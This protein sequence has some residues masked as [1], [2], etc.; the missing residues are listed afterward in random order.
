MPGF[1]VIGHEEQQAINEVFANGGILYRYGFVAQRKGIYKVTEFEKAFAKK[2][3]VNHAQAVNSGTTALVTALHAL[4]IKQG[5]EVITQCHTFVATVEAIL[6]LG[7]TPV[8]T[9]I[10][11]TLNMDPDD[12]A[13]KITKR[14]RAIVPVHMLGVSA[15]M[16]E[17]LS[18][19]QAHGIPVMEDTCQALGASYHG[20]P[21]GTLGALGVFSFDFAK[22]ITTGEGGMVVTNDEALFIKTRSYQDH[23]HDQN[24]NFPRGED[25]HATWGLNFRMMELQGALGI[26]QL[27]KLDSIIEKQKENKKTL[28]TGIQQNA[29][30]TWRELPD[31]EG[32]SADSLVLFV[33]T[34]EKA[35][36][37]AQILKN[38]GIGTKNLPDAINW[39]FATT[40]EHMLSDTPR[41]RGI[42][43]KDE[44]APSA[45]ILKRAIALPIYVHMSEEDI[46]KIINTLGKIL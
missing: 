43:L 37:V 26:S 12:L 28:K 1:E 22:T 23:G 31:E 24:Q 41:Y 29:T 42:N 8:L 13:K 18:L 30:I 14:T 33:D 44:F 27:K 34:E 16:D 19:A 4:N 36:H 20:H 46:D 45:H 3:G 11:N 25:T 2:L 39:H 5:D 21:L 10:N 17:I 35:A 38:N 40:W 32:D 6:A 7:A 9:Q 15:Q